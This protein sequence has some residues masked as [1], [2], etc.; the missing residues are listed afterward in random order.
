[1]PRQDYYS[2]LGIQRGASEKEIR[3]AYRKLARKYHP[4][5]NPNNKEAEEKFKQINAAYEVL[6]DK[7]KRTKYDQYGDQWQFAD[8]F[9]QARTQQQAPRWE[10]EQRSGG[11]RINFGDGVGSLFDELFRGYGA[12]TRQQTQTRRGQDIEYA[13]EITLEEAFSGS[14][15][16]LNLQAPQ[17]C[18]GCNGTGQIQNMPCSVCRGVGTVLKI[19]RLE[20]K[21]PSGVQQGSRVR[22]AGKGEPGYNGGP[23][24]DLYL[25]ISVKPHSRF[26]REGANLHLE[27][28]VPLT[29]AIL[30]GEIQ[31]PTLKSKV[32]LKIPPE[33]QNGRIFNLKGQGMPQLGKTGRGNLL[34]KLKVLLPNNLSSEERELFKRLDEL[35][36]MKGGSNE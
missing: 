4:D 29:T 26:K 7:G 9:A 17:P 14:T 8:Q 5:V 27:V 19:K 6:S 13:I 3:Q 2:V 33:T 35:E 16:I 34:A 31:I 28:E 24:G 22:V 1:M 32:L 18:T 11:G 10:F 23:N 30:G 21:I 36:R 12:G 25:I 20:V 15:R